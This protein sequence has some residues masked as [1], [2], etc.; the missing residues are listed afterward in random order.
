MTQRRAQSGT[1]SPIEL[2]YIVTE[3]TPTRVVGQLTG[4][5][6]RLPS[7]IGA[8]D[9]VALSVDV[10]RAGAEQAGLA[11]PCLSNLTTLHL[12]EVT[13]GLHPFTA[14]CV[15]A[16]GQ[17]STWL[18]RLKSRDG[19]DLAAIS[20]TFREQSDH[21]AP[22]EQD[23]VAAVAPPRQSSRADQR[24]EQIIA[25]ATDLIANKGFANASIRQ[26]AEAAGLHVPTLYQYVGGKD[27]LLELVYSNEMDLMER[28]LAQLDASTAPP[29]QR[30]VEM[31]GRA[32]RVTDQRRRQIGVLNRELRSLDAQARHRV[33]Q[34]YARLLKRY[35]DIV[36]D[37][38]TAGEFRAVDPVVVAN[39]IEAAIDGWALRPFHFL[40][41]DIADYR[42]QL[43]A[44]VTE[45]LVRTDGSD[46]SAGQDRDIRTQ[47]DAC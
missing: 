23:T 28:E 2:S 12:C 6:R 39:L 1:V 22:V 37:G 47:Q 4:S 5:P 13:G 40:N 8:T 16:Q 42:A 26:I 36:E 32:L 31:I 11:F 20:Q 3:C 30:L 15:G 21:A 9:I 44:V 27:E 35:A 7:R 17:A 45:G 29:T 34:R 33:V 24:R 46:R 41:Y 18:F 19:G 38:V 10:A 25:A 14:E 43:I